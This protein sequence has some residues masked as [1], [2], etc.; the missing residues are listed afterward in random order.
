MMQ[1]LSV[2]VVQAFEQLSVS[3]KLDSI[4]LV[5]RN[6]SQRE[7]TRWPRREVSTLLWEICMKTIGDGTCT[8]QSRDRIGSEIKMLFIT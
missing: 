5:Y 7:V 6:S 8:T 2:P 3:P 1:S 4:P